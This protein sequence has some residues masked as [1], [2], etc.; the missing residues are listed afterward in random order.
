[1]AINIF[2]D[3]YQTDKH[4]HSLYR[5]T[6]PIVHKHLLGGDAADDMLCASMTWSHAVREIDKIISENKL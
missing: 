3:Y 6:H 1:M 4:I 2:D 5:S